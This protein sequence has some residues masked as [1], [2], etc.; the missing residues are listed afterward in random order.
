MFLMLPYFVLRHDE[1]AGLDVLYD[2]HERN[3]PIH[4]REWIPLHSNKERRTPDSIAVTFPCDGWDKT[5]SG[6]GR[7]QQRQIHN[8]GYMIPKKSRYSHDN[9]EMI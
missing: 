3:V 8:P 9:C 5:G 4:V 6:E 7:S 2:Q 1:N